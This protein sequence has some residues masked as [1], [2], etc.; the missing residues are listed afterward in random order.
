MMGVVGTALGYQHL[1]PT[2]AT[3]LTLPAGVHVSQILIII[4]VAPV[5]YRDDGV[6]PTTAAGGGMPLPVG[7]ILPYASNL[8]NLQFISATGLVDI[9]FYG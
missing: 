6:A 7:T 5:T 8:K 2:T 4:S 9:A 3:G 1:A